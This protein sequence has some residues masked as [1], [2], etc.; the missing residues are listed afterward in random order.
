MGFSWQSSDERHL[1]VFT[2][3]CLCIFPETSHCWEGWFEKQRVLVI[4]SELRARFSWVYPPCSTQKGTF[5]E[6]AVAPAGDWNELSLAPEHSSRMADCTEVASAEI[7]PLAV[8]QSNRGPSRAPASRCK[9]CP[10]SVCLGTRA[11]QL[12]SAGRPVPLD[13]SEKNVWLRNYLVRSLISAE[14]QVVVLWF[15]VLGTQS[16]KVV[17]NPQLGRNGRSGGAFAG[18]LLVPESCPTSTTGV[19]RGSRKGPSIC[20]PRFCH[21]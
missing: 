7:E 16:A 12:T 14:R 3:R 15:S 2:D 4:P 19:L 5:P 1:R 11:Y 13:K 17:S 18:S 6:D 9:R 21:P 8:P 10:G 20:A